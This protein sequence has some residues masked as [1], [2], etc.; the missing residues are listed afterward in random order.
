MRQK[1]G[2][3]SSL[4]MFPIYAFGNEDM[5]K[6]YLPKLAQGEFIGCFGLTV[7]RTDEE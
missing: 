7:S 2:V 4:V 3:Q 1:I 5:K 6:K